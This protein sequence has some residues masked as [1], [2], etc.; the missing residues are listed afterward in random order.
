MGH[1]RGAQM[2]CR[3]IELLHTASGCPL[4]HVQ[5]QLAKAEQFSNKNK[6]IALVKVRIKLLQ[7]TMLSKSKVAKILAL[8]AN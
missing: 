1:I 4:T 8:V 3:S 5:V 6:V 2:G 7:R